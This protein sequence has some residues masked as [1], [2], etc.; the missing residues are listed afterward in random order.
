MLSFAASPATTNGP[1]D[2]RHRI[3]ASDFQA[4]SAGE[5]ISM[6]VASP[7]PYEELIYS[8]HRERAGDAFRIYLQAGFGRNDATDWLPAGYWGPVT[9]LVSS[10]KAPAFDRGV[11]DMDFLK[12]RT[13]AVS[14]RFKVV[15]AGEKPL[16]S[17]PA[18]TVVVTDVH[19][20]QTSASGERPAAAAG[21]GTRVHDVPLRR[22]LNSQ[23]QWIKDRCQ[24]A[25]LAS[26]LQYYGQT[27]PLEQILPYT[28]DAEYGYPGI[29]PRV[30]AAAREF[31]CE[32]YIERFR[33]WEQVRAALAANKLILCSMRL[34]EGQ[35]QSPPYKSMGN[36]IVVLGGLTDDG[37]VVV[38][39]SALGKSGSGY[40]CQ[41]RQSDF[42]QVWMKNKGGVAMVICPPQGAV[43]RL[44]G[45]LPPFPANRQFP[46]G[47]DH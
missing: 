17:P 4:T 6:P 15:A 46:S 22:Q 44:V 21:Q 18:V 31:G 24:S 39:D 19:P 43:P 37:R 38:T 25:A 29:W 32:G 41:W 20:L 9:N 16:L 36:H 47:D 12:L 27:V 28:F 40:L 5:W 23:G 26:A 45:Q 11:L 42:E 14:F 3:A 33:T 13:K 30:I 2:W 7:F 34:Q 8:W 1:L 35:C 10:R